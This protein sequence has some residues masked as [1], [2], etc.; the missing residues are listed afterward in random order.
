M[1][2]LYRASMVH[3]LSHPPRGEWILIDGRHVQ[4]VGSGEPPQADRVVEL[5]GTTIIPGFVDAH[6]HLTG[7]GVHHQ[8]PEVASARS[9]QELIET[10]RRVVKDKD[11]PVLVHGYDES[12]WDRPDRT[13]PAAAAGDTGRRPGQRSPSGGGAAGAPTGW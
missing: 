9:A 2:T 10:L 11:G 12:K 1:R 3:T 13:H 6:V 7:T 8:A 5:P 4:R